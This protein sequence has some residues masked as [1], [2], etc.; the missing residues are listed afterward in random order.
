MTRR[1]PMVEMLSWLEWL[2]CEKEFFRV[3]MESA[4]VCVHVYILIPLTVFLSAPLQEF[5]G[6]DFM[7]VH[8]SAGY[9]ASCGAWGSP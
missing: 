3:H 4:Y 9:L 5:E 2:G 7:C 8:E 6:I 1:K